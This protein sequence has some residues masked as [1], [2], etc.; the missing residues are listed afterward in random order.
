M[1]KNEDTSTKKK[2]NAK[3]K[4]NTL[5]YGAMAVI[6]IV[7]LVV[8]VFSIQPEPNEKENSGD[9]VSTESLYQF[10]KEGELSFNSSDGKYLASID[11]EFAESDFKRTQGLMYRNRMEENQGMLFVFPLEE[12]QSFWMRNTILS[13]DIMFVNS[14]FEI[15]KIHKNTTPYS[16]QSLPSDAPS[17]YVVEV[18]AGY[19]EKHNIKEGDKIV[20]RRI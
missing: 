18:N 19:A 10:K 16:E 6:V 2:P 13:L 11:I 20:W 4:S 7:S 14:K 5:F 1:K 17:I 12:P 15:V 3:S 9:N 8:I